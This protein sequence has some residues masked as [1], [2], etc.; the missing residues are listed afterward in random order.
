MRGVYCYAD[1]QYTTLWGGG[2]VVYTV[3]PKGGKQLAYTMPI[4]RP[5][6]T[7]KKAQTP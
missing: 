3:P 6:H 4:P 5:W 7:M 2:M 1:K